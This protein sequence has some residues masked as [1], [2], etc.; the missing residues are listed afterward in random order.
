MCNY[1]VNIGKDQERVSER[2][3]FEAMKSLRFGQFKVSHSLRKSPRL[4]CGHI[5]VDN[6]YLPSDGYLRVFSKGIILAVKHHRF[7]LGYI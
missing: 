3:K 2:N 4:L 5:C 6:L 1:A 7:C